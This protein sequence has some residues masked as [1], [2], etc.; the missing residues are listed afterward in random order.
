MEA[1][2]G[3]DIRG[4]SPK[5]DQGS[6]FGRSTSGWVPLWGYCVN[7]APDILNEG[8]Y[9]GGFSNDG[10]FIGPTKAG[11]LAQ[12]LQERLDQGHVSQVVKELASAPDADDRAAAKDF[13]ANVREFMQFC[14]QSGGFGIW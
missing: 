6:Y 11:R 2:V 8:D 3:F 5:S 1:P 9:G 10:H 13:E 12:R 7:M 4:V 14:N